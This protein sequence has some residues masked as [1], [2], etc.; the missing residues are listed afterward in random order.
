MYSSHSDWPLSYLNIASQL[1]IEP[2]E[3]LSSPPAAMQS[4]SL[5]PQDMTPPE[6]IPSLDE[7]L[8]NLPTDLQMLIFQFAG[9]WVSPGQSMTFASWNVSKKWKNIIWYADGFIRL[10]SRIIVDFEARRGGSE[11]GAVDLALLR[12]CK[13]GQYERYFMPKMARQLHLLIKTVLDIPG[14]RAN[15]DLGQALCNA[16]EFLQGYHVENV[17]KVLLSAKQHPARANSSGNVYGFMSEHVRNKR[18]LVGTLKLA[19]RGSQ[20]GFALVLAAKKGSLEVMR[21]LLDWP[22]FAPRADCFRGLAL[23][24]SASGGHLPA[25]ELL[26]SMWPRPYRR[27]HKRSHRLKKS[28]ML[29]CALSAASSGPKA[30]DVL[31]WILNRGETDPGLP[32]ADA[33]NGALLVASSR[34]GH[35]ETVKLLLSWPFHPPQADCQNGEALVMAASKGHN[36]IAMLLLTHDINAPRADCKDGAALKAAVVGKHLTMIRILLSWPVNA[37]KANFGDGQALLVAC[38]AENYKYGSGPKPAD[39]INLLLEWPV[40]PPRA[41]CQDGLPLLLSCKNMKDGPEETDDKRLEA[42]FASKH[43]P[44]ANSFDNACLGECAYKGLTNSAD[45]LIRQPTDAAEINYSN[46]F[47]LLRMCHGIDK[48]VQ[49]TLVKLRQD[50]SSMSWAIEGHVH[51]FERKISSYS[52]IADILL[53]GNQHYMSWTEIS[54]KACSL[55]CRG[56]EALNTLS[57][58]LQSCISQIVIWIGRPLGERLPDKCK[59]VTGKKIIESC[60]R[61]CDKLITDV[62]DPGSWLKLI[63][64]LTGKPIP[65]HPIKMIRMDYGPEESWFGDELYTYEEFKRTVEVERADFDFV[66]GLMEKRIELGSLH[67]YRD[68][69]RDQGIDVHD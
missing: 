65:P 3:L 10:L 24:E 9:A 55:C 33:Q 8:M 49:E 1:Q 12:L 63:L 19:N 67:A 41:D 17:V 45:L 54:P 53:S 5:S 60:L 56:G 44:R 47:A 66:C 15:V 20:P 43:P 11:K 6:S 40:D 50:Y 31:K 37:P 23:R 61:F 30:H 35:I 59:M 7:L 13:A 69:L 2:I 18:D 39:V 25:L 64:E 52:G 22:V 29:D 58:M 46:S 51:N 34:T 32:R 68:Y 16:V 48:A 26:I 28:V 4:D 14:A 57:D 62:D 27:R 36:D 38:L 42:L 21:I